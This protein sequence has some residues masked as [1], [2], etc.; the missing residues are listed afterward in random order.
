MKDNTAAQ[1]ADMKKQTI[2]VEVEMNNITREEAARIAA[3]FFGTHQ[4]E[5]TGTRNDYATWSAWD[6]DR[7]E[8]KFQQDATI[9]GNSDEQCELVTSR[10]CGVHIHIGLKSSV[11]GSHG[12]L[13]HQPLRPR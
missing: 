8:W 7:R 1:I 6:A 5:F 10:G 4:Y 9:C 2:G 11:G 3:E 13:P 12:S